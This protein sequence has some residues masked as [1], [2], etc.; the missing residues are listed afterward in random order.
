MLRTDHPILELV[1]I[2]SLSWNMLPLGSREMATSPATAHRLPQPRV[3]R[4]GLQV[5][6][7]AQVQVRILRALPTSGG[8][9]RWHT[10]GSAGGRRASTAAWSR[11]DSG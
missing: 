11:T 9:L 7:K 6:V 8:L 5:I 4:M 2:L 3:A 10:Y 1:Q